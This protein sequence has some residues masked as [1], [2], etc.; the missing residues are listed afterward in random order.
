VVEAL[1]LQLEELADLVLAATGL[2][3]VEPLLL[4]LQI[5]AA[6]VDQLGLRLL[7]VLV[8]QA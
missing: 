3:V 7:L 2:T 5:L 8:D 4:A 6:V 1:L